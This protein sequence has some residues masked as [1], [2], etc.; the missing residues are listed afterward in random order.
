MI[1]KIPLKIL[2]FGDLLYGSL[3]HISFKVNGIIGGCGVG[4]GRVCIEME[5]WTEVKCLDL[6]FDRHELKSRLY[7]SLSFLI[8]EDS[9]LSRVTSPHLRHL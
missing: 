1:T 6:K 8:T 7:T 3:E 9:A 5:H 2:S 4:G